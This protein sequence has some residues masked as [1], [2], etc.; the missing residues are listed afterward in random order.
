MK[1]VLDITRLLRRASQSTPTGIDRVEMAYVR[2][3]LDSTQYNGQAA[4]VARMRATSWYL[5]ADTVASFIDAMDLRWKWSETRITRRELAT[6]EGFLGVSSGSLSSLKAGGPPNSIVRELRLPTKRLVS[7]ANLLPFIRRP[8]LSRGAVYLNVSH[9]GLKT[10][11]SVRRHGLRPVYFVHDLIPI[12][13]PEYVRP[14]EDKEH[15]Q[16]MRVVLSSGEAI[17]CNST[18]TREQLGVF[19]QRSDIAMPRNFVCPLGIEEEFGTEDV[20]PSP[21]HPFFLAVGTIEPRKNHLVLLHAWRGLV[22]K[23]GPAAPKL[24]IVGRRGWENENVID[25]IERCQSLGGH[26]LECNRLPD[27]HL[28]WLM[29][30]ARAVLFP[31]FAEGYGLPLFEALALRVPVICSN[32]QA[33]IEVAG[34]VPHYLDPVDGLGWARLIEEYAKPHSE[35]RDYQM[36]QLATIKIPRWADHFSV[37]DEIIDSIAAPSPLKAARRSPLSVFMRRTEAV[38]AEASVAPSM[39][40]VAK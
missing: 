25:I 3:L 38:K 1:V 27:V 31:S 17:V 12:T 18:H 7:P 40:S 32:L 4:F 5:N 26:V 37:V 15:E 11:G 23:L 20:E 13:H 9:E 36:G 8:R 28:R 16:R 24:V 6:I 35:L 10:A 22:E 21:S 14:G 33:F 29:K 19:A 2:H 34:P 30:R 39:G